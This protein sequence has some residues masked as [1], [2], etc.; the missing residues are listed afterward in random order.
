M[1][2]GLV[3]FFKLWRGLWCVILGRAS[4]WT[5]FTGL[6]AWCVGFGSACGCDLIV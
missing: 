4:F 1:Q 2:G 6:L 5:E 3:L